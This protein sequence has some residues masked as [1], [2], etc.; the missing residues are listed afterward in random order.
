MRT[1]GSAL[2]SREPGAFLRPE[3]R[4]MLFA[5][6]ATVVWSGNFVICRGMVDMIP[7]A[8]LALCR[9]MI[10]LCALLPFALP[11]LKEDLP[12]LKRH[13]RYYAV[14]SAI[15]IAFF[16]TAIY[17]AGHTV[18]TLNMSLIATTSPLF[19]L[20]L[21]RIFLGEPITRAR[22]AGIVVVVT[23]VILLICRGKLSLLLDLH[24]QS[25]DLL[26]LAA[27][28]A[29]AVYTLQVRKKPD[30]C[31]QSTYLAA[32]FGL[33]ALMLAPVSFSE[34]FSGQVAHFTPATLGALA[35]VGLGASLFAFWCWSKAVAAIGPSKASIIYYSLPLFSGIGAVIFLGEPI[36]W[37]HCVS[38]A[39]IL[40]GLALATKERR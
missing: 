39:L 24:F 32:T 15:G 35:Y 1:R 22:L 37:V 38:G 9:W 8:T 27:A 11:R 16:N 19:T 4:G 18:G 6:L 34:L 2:P 23:G 29:F 12:H 17:T 20:V 13:W 25:G 31:G 21:A 3:G 10:A 14:T 33:G 30:G 40:G 26:M 28:L 7:P 5:L 36:L